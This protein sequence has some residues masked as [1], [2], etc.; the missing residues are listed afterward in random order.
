MMTGTLNVSFGTATEPNFTFYD[1]RNRFKFS[2]TFHGE[3]MLSPHKTQRGLQKLLQ[4][5]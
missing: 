5:C 1:L 3:S 2:D 4:G